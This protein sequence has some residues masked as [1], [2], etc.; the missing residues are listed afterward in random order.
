[1]TV[2][3]FEKQYGQEK[4]YFEYW[5]GEPVQKSVPTWLH[6]LLQKTTMKLLDDA[7]YVSAAEVQLKISDEFQ[8]LPEVTA[9]RPGEVE[10]PYPTRPVEIVVEVLCPDDQ[11]AQ[12]AKQ[13]HPSS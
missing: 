8:P 11:L 13:H 3:Q 7:G 9:V 4:P 1:M 2:E 6:S 10:L 5:F 12:A